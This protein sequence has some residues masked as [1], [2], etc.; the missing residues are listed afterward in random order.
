MPGGRRHTADVAVE[1]TGGTRGAAFA[2]AADGLTAAMCSELPAGGGWLDLS[3]T[4][5]SREAL[6]FEYLDQLLYERD[7]GGVLPA[8]H[9][10]TVRRSGDRT[11]GPASAGGTAE[12]GGWTAEASARAIPL[13]AVTGREVK[14]VTYSEMAVERRDDGWRIYVVFDV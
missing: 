8:D 12:P 14:A 5:E 3:V 7:V 10:C 2:A 11:G 13:A 6:L 1:A 4:A 9:D